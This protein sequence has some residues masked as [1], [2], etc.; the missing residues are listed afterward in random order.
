MGGCGQLF[1][2]FSTLVSSSF[3]IG[4]DLI[5]SLDFLG[6][7][8]SDS[9]TDTVFGLNTTANI[10]KYEEH[11]IWG[12]L[13]IC[14]IFLPGIIIPLPFVMEYIA[15]GESIKAMLFFVGGLF[16]PITLLLSAFASIFTTC[17]RNEL[18]LP[19]T[20]AMVG[21]EAFFESFPQILLQG[22]TILYGYEVTTIQKVTIVASFVL[23]ARTAIVYD[24]VVAE[25]DEELSFKDSMIYTLKVLPTHVTTI[26]F[27]A[28]SFGLTIA[29]LRGWSC[30]PIFVL[31]LELLLITYNRYKTQDK[32]YILM[33]LWIMPFSNLPVLNAHAVDDRSDTT[34]VVTF[35]RLTSVA[36]FTHHTIVLTSILILTHLKPDYLDQDHFNHL[37]L[38]PDTPSF[39]LS[40]G[41]TMALGV[42]GLILSLLSAKRVASVEDERDESAE[43]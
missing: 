11:K 21:A 38:K 43:D 41:V 4:S 19:Y 3:D 14:L 39:Y 22:Y 33:C 2:A 17:H 1:T 35:I 26:S 16:Y 25:A 10:D 36:T 8:V 15:A 32:D 27:R 40:F 42:F 23:L 20:L 34:E 29:F 31:H 12:T 5:N 6:Y 24:L 13:G 7:N 30:I 28:L 9:I 37:I 18:I